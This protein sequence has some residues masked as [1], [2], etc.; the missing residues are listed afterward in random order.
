MSSDQLGF[1]S[2]TMESTIK[3]RF[4]SELMAESMF[5]VSMVPFWSPPSFVVTWYLKI[6]RRK[7]QVTSAE[8]Q[9]IESTS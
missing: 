1:S 7:Y 6:M 3:L 4:W 2:G 5:A 8:D 9:V